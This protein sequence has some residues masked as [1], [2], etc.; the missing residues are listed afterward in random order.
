MA[1]LC[2]AATEKLS[3][4]TFT[5][6]ADAISK[7]IETITKQEKDSLKTEV[8]GVNLLLEK[9]EISPAEADERKK[10]YAEKRARNIEDRVST[11]ERKLSDLVKDKVDG[12]INEHER[13]IL[14]ISYSTSYVEGDSIKRKLGYKRTM[15]QF[16]Y[17][18][19]VNRI[20]NNGTAAEGFKW[21]SDFYEVGIAWNTRILKNHNLLHAK[22][23]LSVQYNN[24][25]PD[26]NQ[27]FITDGNKTLLADFGRDIEMARLRYVNLVVPAHLEF[28]FS[29]KRTEGDKT[30]YPIQ[31]SFRLGVGGYIG[32]NIKEKQIIR[33]KDDNGNDIKQ[34][35][36]GDYNV[37]DF[38]YGVSA[39]VSY[40]GVGIYA[41]YDLNPVFSNNEVD[42]NNFSLGIR[43]DM[44]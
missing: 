13:R 10:Q 22:Y 9:N 21:R 34:K 43:F 11:E 20:V 25:R 19:G 40:E 23:G 36:K 27:V 41:K 26:N 32:A 17:A 3:A 37:N 39:Y 12:K 16:V 4:Q 30:F 28:D 14:G 15:S 24:L 18:L 29:K 42:Y 35:I 2:L 5:Q 6:R 8:D 31:K 33:F 7:N 44:N 38:I 1:L